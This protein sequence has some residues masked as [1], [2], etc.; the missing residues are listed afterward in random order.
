MCGGSLLTGGYQAMNFGQ[1]F[2]RAFPMFR[3]L[4][5]YTE[6]FVDKYPE[7]ASYEKHLR[8]QT[9]AGCEKPSTSSFAP[10]CQ[11]PAFPQAHDRR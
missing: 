9:Q 5:S 7:A 2:V 4:P 3:S 8:L 1:A 11:S 10:P 6:S